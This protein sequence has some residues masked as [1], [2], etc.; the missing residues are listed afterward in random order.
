MSDVAFKNDFLD[1]ASKLDAITNSCGE[2]V[3]MADAISELQE[4]D[5]TIRLLQKIS[6]IQDMLS[7][8]NCVNYKE[9][10]LKKGK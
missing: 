6:K 3:K 9:S 7:A 10:I 4:H 1:L 5:A 8:G 2:I